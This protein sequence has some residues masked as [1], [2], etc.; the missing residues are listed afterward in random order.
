MKKVKSAV[1]TLVLLLSLC[2][3]ALIAGAEDVVVFTD[4]VLEARV[5][6]QMDKP[7]GDITAADAER[8]DQLSLNRE[9]E[10]D[11]PIRDISSLQHFKNLF[12]LSLINNEVEDISALSGMAGLKFLDLGGNF[13]SDLSPL[14]G[15]PLEVLA[16]WG[17]RVSD[18]SPLGSLKNLNKLQLEGNQIADFSPLAN[19]ENLQYLFVREN[20]TLDYTALAN[21]FPNLLE[22]DFENLTT[23]FDSAEVI[24]FDDSVLERKVREAL[25]KPEGDITAGDAAMLEWLNADAD[26]NAPDSERIRDISALRYFVNLQG[27]NLNSNAIQDI[28]PLAELTSLQHLWLGGNP[29]NDPEL[30][31]GLTKMVRMG[32]DGTF[33]EITFLGNR[34]DL[35]E[36]RIDALRVLPAD[37][38][39]LKKLN[40]FC[41]LGGEL[42]DISLLAQVPSLT[43]ID[44]SW[45]MV[46]DI[47]PLASL[48]LTELYL[49][50]NPIEDY[51]PVKD[52]IPQLLGKDFDYFEITPAENPDTVI[53]FPDPVLER[54]I[55]AA[56]SKPEGDITARDAANVTDLELG[57]EWQPQ[58]PQESMI[59]NLQGMEYF[60]NLRNLHAYFNGISDITP[61]AGLTQLRNLDLGGNAVV[62]AGP[63][64]GLLNLEHLILFGSRIAD[65]T[66]LAGLSKLGSVNLSG[67]P[68]G[69]LAPLAG[70]TGLGSVFLSGCGVEDIGSLAALTNLDCLELNDN[71]VSDLSPLSGMQRL[72]ILKLKNNPIQDYSPITDIYPNLQDEDFELGQVFDVDVPLKPENPDA[73][74]PIGD[75][76]L[77]AILREA[78]DVFDRPLTRKDLCSIGKLVPSDDRM[79]QNVS[80]LSPLQYCL[81]LEGLI[82]NGSQVQDLDKLSMLE[83]LSVLVVTDSRVANIGPLEP[84]ADQLLVLELRNN[85]IEDISVVA[86]MVNLNNL[87]LSRNRIT[88][89]SPLYGL[90][91]LGRLMINHNLVKDASGLHDIAGSLNEK[92]FDPNQPLDWN[93]EDEGTDEGGNSGM[94]QPENPDAVIV[95]ADPV[96]E[97]RIRKELNKPEGELTAG[98]AAT[99]E[100][101]RLGNEWQESF[102]EGSQF[103]DLSGI[104]HFINLRSLDISWNMVEDIGKLAG[105]TNLE[106][107]KA[108]GNRISDLSPL[109]GLTKLWNLNI[110]GNQVTDI[111]ALAGL[112]NLTELYLSGNPVTDYLPVRDIYPQLTQKDF[113][114]E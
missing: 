71:Y 87:D 13:I 100:E 99:V 44:L 69:G 81:N 60:I 67:N 33:R 38:P 96:L 34:P 56:I 108:F 74:V 19:L 23:P 70:L 90:T 72:A 15:L 73:E 84:L 10:D 17:N 102:P 42:T 85:Q 91:R 82:I 86:L 26:P 2:V 22:R 43:V 35:E 57:N 9:N 94:L 45:N 97:L 58:I 110:G 66:P 3:P 8:V 31:S 98:E 4:P 46:S 77:E 53:A 107:I 14:S 111:G 37:L 27:L 65:I 30:L 89:L 55:R 88:D 113:T 59:T 79:W 32:F 76:A 109:A 18:I 62:D 54:K 61:L 114:M 48:P 41:S 47:A 64:A 63:L 21:I 104:E 51:S 36:L 29:I 49:A 20:A 40:I 24:R 106:Y 7:E 92:D 6:E 112:A 16:V 52:L 68:V 12:M 93:G 103:S 80:D 11:P 5:R 83:K 95:F 105:L 50:G 25:N 1:L 39:R 78:T 28:S 75:T 101:L